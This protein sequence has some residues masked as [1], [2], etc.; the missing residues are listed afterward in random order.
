MFNIKKKIDIIKTL[1]DE[2]IRSSTIP[3]YNRFSQ[4]PVKFYKT[5]IG[6]YFLPIDAPND[7]IVNHMKKGKLFE[8][9]VIE[10]SKKYINEGSSVLD[11]GAN[12]GQMSIEFSRMVGD[13]GQVFSFEADDFVH[14]LLQ[15]NIDIN[16]CQNIRAFL[17]AVYDKSGEMKY[18]PVQDFKRFAA[19]GSYGLD[20]NAKTGRAIK[21]IA[22]D[23]LH[24]RDK[25]SF[26]K[27]DV[28]GS[29]L[30]ALRGAVQSIKEH[31]MPILFEYEEQFQMEFNTSFQD[32]LDFIYSISYKVERT[33]NAINYLI[34]PDTKKIV[35][36][37]SYLSQHNALPEKHRIDAR[38]LNSN[39][40]SAKLAERGLCKFLK[41]RQEVQECTAFLLQNG[42]V[43]HNLTCKDWDLAHI[44][45]E[46]GDGNFLDMGSSDSY[47]LRNISLKR[48]HGEMY[49]IDLREPDVPVTRV[50]YIVGDLMDSKLPNNYFTNITC[51]SVIE[52]EVEFAK[53]AREASRLLI[54]NG[55]LFVTFDY[56]NPKVVPPIKMYGLKWKPLDRQD[57]ERLFVTCE[58]NNLHLI[59]DMDWSLGNAV[60]QYGYYSPHKNI[61]YTFGIAVFEKKIAI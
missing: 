39:K 42:F 18:F 45:P 13:S 17:A 23:D 57:L 52:H 21:T 37:P 24:I 54:K 9:E 43:S 12:F 38:G 20:P 5:A 36:V 56:W 8:P 46:I 61:N 34:V 2:R 11:L 58:Q 40:V 29:D 41:S 7:V 16:N 50:K 59:Q 27:V 49:G 3:K 48:I 33:V 55:K 6:N 19:Y 44:I 60:I 10:I 14:H 1:V 22:I 47:I 4:K 15:K 32:Y 51:L 30:F 53:F 26:M 25:I 35:S 28:Q 31:Q